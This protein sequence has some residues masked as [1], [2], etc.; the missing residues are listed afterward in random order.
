MSLDPFPPAPKSAIKLV[1][2]RKISKIDG[3]PPPYFHRFFRTIDGVLVPKILH[4]NDEEEFD[5]KKG[6]NDD[7]DVWGDD[8]VKMQT[9]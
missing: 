3:P 5:N 7:D 6:H 8:V 2:F 4:Q 9:R 1:F